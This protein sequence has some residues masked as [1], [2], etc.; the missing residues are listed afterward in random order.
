MVS[1]VF[2]SQVVGISKGQSSKQALKIRLGY[3]CYAFNSNTVKGN[4]SKLLTLYLSVNMK[5]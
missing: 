1:Y 2:V 5:G 4:K 3:K